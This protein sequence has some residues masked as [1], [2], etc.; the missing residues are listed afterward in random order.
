MVQKEAKKVQQITFILQV[1]RKLSQRV[2][3][4]FFGNE[5]HPNPIKGLRAALNLFG[6]CVKKM[7]KCEKETAQ[8]FP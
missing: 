3:S 7:N 4:T 8:N 5:I 6:N 1:E 2:K